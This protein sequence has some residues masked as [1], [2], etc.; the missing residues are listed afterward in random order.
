MSPRL[1]HTRFPVDSV[2]PSD[3]PIPAVWSAAQ[4]QKPRPERN[5]QNG[6]A[7]RSIW[8]VV[9]RIR[10]L[11][12]SS[13][14]IIHHTSS[15]QTEENIC[16]NLDSERFDQ[17]EL[18]FDQNSGVWSSSNH[19]VPG[20]WKNESSTVFLNT[21]SPR[22]QGAPRMWYNSPPQ[23]VKAIFGVKL[24]LYEKKHTHTHHTFF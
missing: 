14:I 8:R 21:T 6:T 11:V 20:F 7:R 24:V 22:K 12:T 17:G 2:G 13:Y 5:F 9:R 3:W 23:S 16:S 1:L 10:R 4:S 19:F 15:K 18:K